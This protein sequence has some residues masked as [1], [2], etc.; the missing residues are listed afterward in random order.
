M[1]TS[2]ESYGNQLDNKDLFMH[3]IIDAYS[4]L[5]ADA[6]HC[7]HCNEKHLKTFDNWNPLNDYND[8]WKIVD[9]L[10]NFGYTGYEYD[11]VFYEFKLTVPINNE[12]ETYI[13]EGLT[14]NQS[15]GNTLIEFSKNK[16]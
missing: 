15:V 13:G 9:L 2:I 14:F 1:T 7:E 11:S 6:C 3:E 5:I 8:V 12:Y 16:K 4:I 10:G